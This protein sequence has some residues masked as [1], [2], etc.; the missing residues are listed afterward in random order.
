MKRQCKDI[1]TDAILVYMLDESVRRGSP[2][3]GKAYGA[4]EWFCW[5]T[6]SPPGQEQI[7]PTVRAAMPDWVC[8]KLALSKMRNLMSKGLVDGCDCGC[9]GD[10]T[11]T[12]KGIERAK[13][14][15]GIA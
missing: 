6:P 9:R 15:K 14:A 13:K 3:D 1:P 2:Q 4:G 5:F 11:L 8:D 10:F 7:M 12:M